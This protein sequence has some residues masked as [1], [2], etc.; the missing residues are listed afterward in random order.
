MAS[1]ASLTMAGSMNS[2]ALTNLVIRYAAT[3][4]P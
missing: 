2:E 4:P 3:A 1:S